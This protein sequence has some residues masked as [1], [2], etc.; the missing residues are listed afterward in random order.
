[1]ATNNNKLYLEVSAEDITEIEQGLKLLENKRELAR[2][3]FQRK[4]EKEGKVSTFTRKKKGPVEL[5]VVYPHDILRSCG[6]IGY[7]GPSCNTGP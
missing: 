3:A 4:N 6:L 5:K 7:V 1:M 2:K